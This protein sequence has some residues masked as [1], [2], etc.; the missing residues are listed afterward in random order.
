MS[1]GPGASQCSKVASC[2]KLVDV[3]QANVIV[4]TRFLSNRHSFDGK[5]MWDFVLVYVFYEF[6]VSLIRRFLIPFPIMFIEQE[7][8]YLLELLYRHL[9]L[10]V[11]P[12]HP[13]TSQLTLC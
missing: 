3:R 4:S 2:K 1:V 12:S 8:R 9:K 5:P 13:S 11:I 10:L 6:K 7:H